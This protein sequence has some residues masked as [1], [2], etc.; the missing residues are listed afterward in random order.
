MIW[1]KSLPRAG[2][3]QYNSVIALLFGSRGWQH[4]QWSDGDVGGATAFIWSVVHFNITGTPNPVKQS[5][6]ITA[7]K[8]TVTYLA[9][10]EPHLLTPLSSKMTIAMNKGSL[11]A[12]LGPQWQYLDRDQWQGTHNPHHLVGPW[13][14]GSPWGTLAADC[15]PHCLGCESS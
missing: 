1:A 11:V 12:P 10:G 7:R 4:G 8:G 6:S 15:G 3:L 2:G 9:P 14:C 13:S 5:Q